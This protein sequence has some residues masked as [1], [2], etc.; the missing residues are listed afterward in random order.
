[1]EIIYTSHIFN[2]AELLPSHGR[3]AIIQDHIEN[4][5]ELLSLRQAYCSY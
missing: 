1:M 4:I 2:I 5:V 3:A